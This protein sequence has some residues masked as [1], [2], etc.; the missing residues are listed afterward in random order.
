MADPFVSEIRIFGFSF[1]PAGWAFCNGQLMP[2]AQNTALFS[3][4]GTTFGGDG[5]STFA[6]PDLRGRVP[7]NFGQGPGLSDYDEG[8]SGGT[9]AVTLIP[10]QMG[11]HTHSVGV[12]GQPA[13]D[14]DP[15]GQ[16]F[17]PGVGVSYWS[18]QGPQAGLDPRALAAAG[19]NAPHNNLQP[20][21]VAN[22]CIALQGIYPPH[23]YANT[24]S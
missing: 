2:L 19:G 12:S 21:L 1:P 23:P 13:T 5:Q 15:A 22:F 18:T 4:L 16:S 7:I 14:R 11:T 10:S 17:A 6:L 9:A 3:L 24:A 20:Y 8:D